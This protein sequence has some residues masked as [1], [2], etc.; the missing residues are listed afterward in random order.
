LVIAGLFLD[1]ASK[2]KI[3]DYVNVTVFSLTT[4]I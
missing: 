4:C 1:M 2:L 3:F